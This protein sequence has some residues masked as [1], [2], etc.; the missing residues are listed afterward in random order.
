M[1]KFIATKTAFHRG[2]RIRP[3][4]EFDEADDFKASWA[5][6]KAAAKTAANPA[7]K[8]GARIRTS[9]EGGEGESNPEALL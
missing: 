8:K 6:P 5:V 1:A 9:P 3:N 7:A 2:H 4:Q